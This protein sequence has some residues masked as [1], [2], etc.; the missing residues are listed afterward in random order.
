MWKAL[1]HSLDEDTE[2]QDHTAACGQTR[3]WSQLTELS[4]QTYFAPPLLL[5]LWG[6]VLSTGSGIQ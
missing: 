1:A 5:H 3:G 6:S 4:A 2:A